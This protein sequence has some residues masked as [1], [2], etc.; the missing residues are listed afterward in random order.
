MSILAIIPARGW[1]KRIHK[2]NIKIFNGKPIISYSIDAAISSNIFDEIMVSTDDDE[3]IKVAKQ[4]WAIVPFIR[5]E[6]NSNDYATTIDVILEVID[7]YKKE[8]KEFEYVCCIYPCAPFLTPNSL[9]KSFNKLIKYDFDCIFPI[10]S[11][12]SPIQRAL[13]IKKDNHIEMFN[14]EFMQTRSQDLE[15]SYHDVWQFYFLN[16]KEII[17][18]KRLWT[19][20]TSYIEISELECQDIDN[21]DDWKLAELKYQLLNKK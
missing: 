13:K 18:Q 19:D 11:Y 6:L 3:I 20:N 1:S 16:T 15:K 10:V 9:K 12:A 4:Y 21:I 7:S 17:K 5:T 2:K 8:W 14:P